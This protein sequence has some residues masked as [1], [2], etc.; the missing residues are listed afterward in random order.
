MAG[1]RE[2]SKGDGEQITGSVEVAGGLDLRGSRWQ[3]VKYA[4]FEKRLRLDTELIGIRETGH[5]RQDVRCRNLDGIVGYR[6]LE[7][8]ITRRGVRNARENPQNNK[9]KKRNPKHCKILSSQ[10]IHPNPPKTKN[11]PNP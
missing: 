11:L 9:N 5:F 3:L 8:S 1:K 10:T 6:V 4:F 7:M 2:E